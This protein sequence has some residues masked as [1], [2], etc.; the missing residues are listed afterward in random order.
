MVFSLL[1][2][3]NNS[4]HLKNMFDNLLNQK[5][6]QS[7]DEITLYLGMH[8]EIVNDP[9]EWWLA[10]CTIYPCLSRMAIN[11]LMIPSEF[12]TVLIYCHLF[13]FWLA[14]SV[15]IECLFS[16][17]CILLPHL[18]NGL[19]SKSVSTLMCLGDW[20]THGLILDEDILSITKGEVVDDDFDWRE[21]DCEHFLYIHVKT[22]RDNLA[23]A[24]TKHAKPV[25]LCKRSKQW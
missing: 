6:V 25:H 4:K 9:L 21:H 2:Y 18:W 7:K 12:S 10:Q 14:T 16:R 1:N 8:M 22:L 15:D 5:N 17:G 3:L 24:W 11:Y 23:N 13:Q 19:S 20:C